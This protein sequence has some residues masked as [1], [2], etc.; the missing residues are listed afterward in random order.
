MQFED[1][2]KLTVAAAMDL[3]DKALDDGDGHIPATIVVPGGASTRLVTLAGFPD[4]DEARHEYLAEFAIDELSANRVP[5]WGFVVAA[6]V[7]DVDAVVAVYGAR[8]QAPQVTAAPLGPDG[9]G[10][11]VAPEELDPTALPFLHPLQHVVD[12]L[13]AE[14]IDRAAGPLD[15]AP[16]AG[17]PLMDD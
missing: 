2:R 9:L 4:E 10:D 12:S 15:H 8:K 17:L 11:F 5:A 7:N 1:L 14:P 6:E 13:P 3:V 16:D